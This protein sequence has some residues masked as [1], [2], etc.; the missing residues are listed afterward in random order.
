MGIRKGRLKIWR[1][2]AVRNKEAGVQILVLGEKKK[3]FGVTTRKK[4]P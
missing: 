2:N 1:K 3:Y 4:L